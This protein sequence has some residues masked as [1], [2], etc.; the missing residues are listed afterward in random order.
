MGRFLKR[1]GLVLILGL[2]FAIVAVNSSLSRRNSKWINFEKIQPGMTE[3]DVKSIMG[4]TELYFPSG[5]AGPFS[6]G[7]II[8]ANWF[9]DEYCLQV[10]FDSADDKGEVIEIRRYPVRRSHFH[11]LLEKLGLV[12]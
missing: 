9:S 8:D 6:S 10:M 5:V 1:L 7:W 12:K 11:G 4:E 2:A 3:A